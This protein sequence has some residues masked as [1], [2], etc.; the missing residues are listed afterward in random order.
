ML[1]TTSAKAL[2][3]EPSMEFRA[4]V[5]ENYRILNLAGIQTIMPFMEMKF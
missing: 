2:G 4:F 1:T 5:E 3:V